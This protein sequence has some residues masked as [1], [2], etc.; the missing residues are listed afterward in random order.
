MPRKILRSESAQ[1]P[2]KV[3]LDQTRVNTLHGKGTV[4]QRKNEWIF[5]QLDKNG[6]TIKTSIFLVD[7]V[8]IA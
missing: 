8:E 7:L 3:I 1:Y 6:S 2:F 4:R 5:V